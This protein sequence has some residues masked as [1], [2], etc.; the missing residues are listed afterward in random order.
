M[1]IFI[2]LKNSQ[3][4]NLHKINSWVL[5]AAYENLFSEITLFIK[6]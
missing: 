4:K 1:L 6:K 3:G 5:L 2:G